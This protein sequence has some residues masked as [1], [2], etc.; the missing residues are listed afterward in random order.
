MT[1]ARPTTR[2]SES[3]CRPGRSTAGRPAV[4]ERGPRRTEARRRRAPSARGSRRRTGPGRGCVAQSSSSGVDPLIG[5]C[6]AD[7]HPGCPYRPPTAR[8]PRAGRPTTSGHT[9]VRLGDT[10]DRRTLRRWRAVASPF[11]ASGP[12]LRAGRAP[13]PVAGRLRRRPRRRRRRQRRAVRRRVARRR[14]RGTRRLIRAARRAVRR[15]RGRGRRG[16]RVGGVATRARRAARSGTR[17]RCR[18]PQE[19]LRTEGRRAPPARGPGLTDG[20]GRERAHGAARRPLAAR[21]RRRA[22]PVSEDR[23]FADVVPFL[24]GRGFAPVAFEGV[25]DDLATGEMLQA[26]AI[27]A[28][29]AHC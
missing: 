5:C 15:A 12:P 3:R 8:V 19:Q 17:E 11:T 20:R 9:I 28:R 27:F 22:P 1:G 7:L 26:D 29:R 2:R 24:A 23:L 13:R 21:G 4:R 16:S 25:L 10:G 14:L 6:E 18:G